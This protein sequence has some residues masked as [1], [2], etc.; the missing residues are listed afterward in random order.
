MSGQNVFV[1]DEGDNS[2]TEANMASDR[3]VHVIAQPGLDTPDGIAVEDGQVW[4]A[5]SASNAATQINAANGTVVATV[6]G[7]DGSYGFWDPSTV[8]AAAGN[9]YIA[10]PYGTSP[11]VTKVSATGAAPAWYMCNTNGPY[12]FSLLSAFAISGDDLW[13]ASRSGAN[14]LTPAAKTGSLTEM[15]IGSGSLIATYPAPPTSSTTTTSTTT[16][17]TP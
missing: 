7:T 16:T 6:N 4:V 5:D 2:V 9:V 12:Y 17:T 11:M 3:L 14:S 13:V 15:S 1:A 10:T 8:I